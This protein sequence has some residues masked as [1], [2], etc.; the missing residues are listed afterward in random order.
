M[1]TP[2]PYGSSDPGPS[3]ARPGDGAP[4]NPD[5]YSP[6]RGH[7]DAQ[8]GFTPAG[9]Q[10]APPNKRKKGLLIAAGCGCLALLGFGVIGCG[11]LV[12]T[13]MDSP[14]PTPTAQSPAEPETEDATTP[15]ETT[16]EETTEAEGGGDEVPEEYQSALSEAESY[17]DTL[18]L[19]EQGIYDLLT[20]DYGG[21]FSD[22]AAQYAI[23]NL[24]VDWNAN[25]LA[26][27]ESYS[28][29]L[30]MSKQGIYDQLVS[31][32]G[33]QFTPEQA[34]YAID[35]IDADWNE[36]ALESA[37]SYQ[38]TLDMSPEEIRDQLTSEYGGQFTEE[39]ADYAIE[40]L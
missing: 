19:S 26:S 29:H 18:N 36:N 11:A 23:D 8:G 33:E 24:D 1:S 39:Q 31:E 35:T 25:A 40:N 3:H 12:V 27:A 30:H 7:H 22:E 2:T 38:D 28:E 17:S 6:E 13:T 20:S 14:E 10:A 21:Q 5:G 4:G 32:Y 16:P 15:E 34:Q 37:R 9:D